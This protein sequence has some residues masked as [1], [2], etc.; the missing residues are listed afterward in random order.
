MHALNILNLLLLY[1][2]QSSNLNNRDCHKYIFNIHFFEQVHTS[3]TLNDSTFIIIECSFIA[4]YV[5]SAVYHLS[6]LQLYHSI[7][8]F[9]PPLSL[10]SSLL[11]LHTVDPTATGS[12]CFLFHPS[13]TFLPVE[14]TAP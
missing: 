7:Y 11:Y 13:P 1:M 9:H 4:T 5:Y 8:C 2:L 3:N 12:R 10:C 6:C 14:H